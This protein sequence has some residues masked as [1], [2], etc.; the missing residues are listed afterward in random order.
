MIQKIQRDIDAIQNVD[1]LC[2]ANKRRKISPPRRESEDIQ[3]SEDE[4]VQSSFSASYD[5]GSKQDVVIEL[6]SSSFDDDSI[7]ENSG[8]CSSANHFTPN[9]DSLSCEKDSKQDDVIELESSSSD[10][11]SVSGHSGSG[12]STNHLSPN[13]DFPSPASEEVSSEDET[14]GAEGDDDETV[15][16]DMHTYYA[17]KI[18]QSKLFMTTQRFK[19]SDDGA[20][21]DLGNQ[22]VDRELAST[23][24]E[25]FDPM[26]IQYHKKT[27]YKSKCY[28]LK[29]KDIIVGIKRFLSEKSCLCIL[30]AKFD[31]TLLGQESDRV[32]YKADFL[33]G[34]YVQV[35]KCEKELKLKKLGD[36]FQEV[37]EI[38]PLIYQPQTPGEWYTFGYFYDRNIMK[39]GATRKALRSIDLFAGAGGSLQGYVKETL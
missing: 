25:P 7:S 30:I 12:S 15:V 31:E 38:P 27:F 17:P 14:N 23:D 19:I 35:F 8:S 20:N 26:S 36:V 1:N 32:N 33:Q 11:N 37:A 10:D 5:D 16:S 3:R 34:T 29:R 9:K 4:S 2:Q 24:K 6:E 22:R 13:A 39:Q 21:C 28:R 18:K